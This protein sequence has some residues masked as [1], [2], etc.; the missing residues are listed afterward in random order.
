[1]PSA[2]K[3]P[4]AG[5]VY[6]EGQGDLVRNGKENG[7][8]CALWRLGLKVRGGDLVRNG[9]ENEKYCA[10]EGFWVEGQ[11]D[12]VRNGKENEKLWCS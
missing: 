1:M 9:K 8:Y 11:R 7:S 12:L 10:M 4:P 2:G 6:L 5:R 3:H